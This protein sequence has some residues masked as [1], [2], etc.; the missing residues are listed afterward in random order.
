MVHFPVRRRAAPVL[1]VGL[2]LL[3]PVLSGCG[4]VRNAL[5]QDKQPPD[6]F[7]VVARAP[8]SVP[9]NFALRPPTPG[10]QR[11]QEPLKRHG[12]RDLIVKST[13]AAATSGTNTAGTSADN[14]LRRLL[15]TDQAEPGIRETVNR[16]TAA[17]VYA[18]QQLI[19]K[20]LF[21][22]P[23]PPK[24][25]VVDA[26]KEKKRLQENAALGK[27]IDEG[28]TPTIKRKRGGILE[29]LF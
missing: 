18:D 6:E 13:G 5:G 16:E 28:E 21:W 10:A 27:R 2:M 12:A 8:L 9:P 11:P 4:E 19:D 22:R 24:G 1:L 17:F 20:I 7:A 15:G 26:E 14:T 23:E 3:G 29:G 25:I